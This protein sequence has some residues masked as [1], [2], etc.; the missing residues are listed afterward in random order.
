VVYCRSLRTTGADTYRAIY[1]VKL[2]MPFMCFM[3]SKKITRETKTSQID[4]ELISKRLTTA[5]QDYE[6]RQW[7][8]EEM[9]TVSFRARVR[10]LPTL[11]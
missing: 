10:Y 6:A 7:Q 9:T 1:A 4:V 3:R 2:S 11:G 8:T 5:A